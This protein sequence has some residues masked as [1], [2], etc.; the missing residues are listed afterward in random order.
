MN[1]IASFALSNEIA[2][3]IASNKASTVRLANF[4]KMDLILEIAISMG[5]KSGEYGGRCNTRAPADS[6]RSSILGDLCAGR[7]SITTIYPGIRF[8]TNPSRTKARNVSV[9]VAPSKVP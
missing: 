8:G 9:S 4:R 2:W 6:I 3:S 5:L 7:L 1:P